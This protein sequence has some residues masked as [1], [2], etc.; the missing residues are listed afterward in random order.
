M[1]NWGDFNRWYGDVVDIGTTFMPFAARGFFV[2][3]RR[4]PVGLSRRAG[5]AIAEEQRDR[6]SQRDHAKVL[7]FAHRH[8]LALAR[9]R[10]P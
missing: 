10:E 4:D 9:V 2:T 1:A 7:G 6:N 3:A 5:G 8:G